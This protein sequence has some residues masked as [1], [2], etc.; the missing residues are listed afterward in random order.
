MSH[1]LF[2]RLRDFHAQLKEK[3]ID[4]PARD[5]AI[6]DSIKPDVWFESSVVWEI[7]GADLSIS[8]KYTAAIGHVAKDKG[9]SLRFP[10]FIRIRDDKATT[11]ATTSSQV[12][13]DVVVLYD[14]DWKPN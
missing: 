1:R 11:Q 12:R 13:L 4:K 14:A 5:Y 3:V 7:L 2:A 6:T 9:I 10:R 8:P